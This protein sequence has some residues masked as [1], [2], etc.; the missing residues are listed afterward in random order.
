MLGV[1]SHRI[2]YA[3]VQGYV[4]EPLERFNNTRVFSESDVAALRNYFHGQDSSSN[5]KEE[6]ER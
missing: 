4:P 2:A 1:K 5:G 6:T 3:L